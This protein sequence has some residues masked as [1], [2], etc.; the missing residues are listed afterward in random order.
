[1]VGTYEISPDRLRYSFTLRDG[2]K[3]HD[4]EPVGALDCIASLRRWMAR[5]ALG[6]SL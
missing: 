6:Q 4:G 5:D 3:F 2:L 1:M